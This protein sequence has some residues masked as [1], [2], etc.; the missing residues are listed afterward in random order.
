[1][2]GDEWMNIR[3]D[4]NKGMNYTEL[5]KKYG[6]DPRT[7]KKYAKSSNKPNYP[8][9]TSR[10]SKI[11]PFKELIDEKLTEAPYSAVRIQEIITEHGFDSKYTIVKDYVRTKKKEL[12]KQATVRFE[13]M[14]GLQGQVDWAHFPN[15]RVMVDG[16]EHKLYCFLMILGFSR[17]RYIEFV[18]DMSTDTLIQCH[19]NAF[20]Y[21]GGYPDEIL[22]DNMKQVVLK[23]LL[24]QSDS[25]M[26]PQFEDFAGFYG[27]APILCRPYRGQTKGKVERTVSYVRNNLMIGIKYES[28]TD[29][30]HQA[31]SW[32]NKVNAKVHGTTGKVPFDVLPSEKLNPLTREFQIPNRAY[33]KIGKDC[34]VSFDGNKYSVPS[35]FAGRDA[36]IKV[37][38]QILSIYYREKVI[39]QHRINPGHNVMN[40]N[41]HHYEPLTKRQ[42]Q[43]VDN[44]LL[45]DT[46]IL[47]ASIP[48]IDLSVYDMGVSYE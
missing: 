47:Y 12:N 16:H 33:R 42:S 19:I 38:G 7:A 31:S 1:M 4:Y 34:L 48:D 32:C 26:N 6:I 23:R 36:F 39:A 3:A 13:T 9:N 21:F 37:T 40:I 30:N 27:Y 5:S 46:D 43:D 14:P 8:K 29:L 17:M 24:K 11:D 2:I 20:R 10:T 25:T 45:N 22:Y 28:L 15:H 18:T 44:T 41:P 35:R